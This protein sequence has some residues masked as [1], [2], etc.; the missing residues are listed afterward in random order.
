MQVQDSQQ[1]HRVQNGFQVTNCRLNAVRG[2][3]QP[4]QALNTQ[5]NSQINQQ[6]LNNSQIQYSNSCSSQQTETSFQ[7]SSQPKQAE[8]KS[9]EQLERI[10]LS[11]F[12]DLVVIKQE[13]S[14]KQNWNR[15]F[16]ALQIIRSILKY[17]P[18]EVNNIYEFY[19]DIIVSIFQSNRTL[20]IKSCLA[21]LSETFN[22]ART[23][24]LKDEIIQV[25]IKLLFQ[26]LQN[27]CLKP[28]DEWIKYVIQC[29][30]Q[31]V[32]DY[33]SAYLTLIQIPAQ[34]QSK[35]QIH[36]ILEFLLEQKKNSINT[37][38]GTTFIALIRFLSE[39]IKMT[40]NKK[41]QS[42][43]V[44]LCISLIEKIG[45]D[46]FVQLIQNSLNNEQM[47]NIVESIQTYIKSINTQATQQKK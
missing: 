16:E 36:D 46:S 26:K 27:N 28:L 5:Q 20:M 21:L 12:N 45:E 47:Q 38:Q 14:N 13:L 7:T 3:F 15:Q 44:K 8:V 33:D 39:N 17:H 35:I 11:N 31:N 41:L 25:F 22:L 1:L 37:L 4:S 34:Q 32:F 2:S 42:P 30:A 18:E 6:N 19:G 43:S 23:Y 29:F 9:F 24:Q 40:T 10:Q